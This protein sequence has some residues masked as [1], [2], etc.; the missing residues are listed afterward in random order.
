[1]KI[2]ILEDD[3][4]ANGGKAKNVIVVIDG[5]RV[6]LPVKTTLARLSELAKEIKPLPTLAPEIVPPIASQALNQASVDGV[7]ER[8]DIVRCVRVLE[9]A[10][11][12]DVDIRVGGEYRVA[13][14]KKISSGG[15]TIVEHYE[16]IDD[17][18]AIPRRV[19]VS[20]VEIVFLRK[21]VPGPRKVLVYEE[22]FP[23][24]CGEPVALV[25]DQALDKYAGK[26]YKCGKELVYDRPKSNSRV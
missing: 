6:I 9:R 17:N 25:L 23:C 20:P 24:A 16:V 1:M 7:I 15:Q 21:H 10:Q 26:C 2:E 18:A 3:G 8:E 4:I 14:I 19:M 13:G 12:A 5:H 11:G 22:M